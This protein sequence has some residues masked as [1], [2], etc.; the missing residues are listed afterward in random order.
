YNYSRDMLMAKIAVGLGGR[1]AEELPRG[2]EHVTTGAENDFRVVTGLAKRMV[3]RW[4]MSDEVGVVFAAYDEA[5]GGLNMSRVD[6][7]ARASQARTL[8]LDASGCPVP[9]GS[10]EPA[11]YFASSA[12]AS[13]ASDTPGSSL[14][15]IVDREVKKIVDQGYITALHSLQE[16]SDQ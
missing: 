8:A 2:R 10:A 13:V 14:S 6:L 7:M 11:S 4:G 9:N 1:V 15:A 3:T 5:G 12:P 16:H